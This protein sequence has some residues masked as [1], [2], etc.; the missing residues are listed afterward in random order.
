MK[1]DH[2]DPSDVIKKLG[3]IVLEKIPQ[4]HF[5]VRVT[6]SGGDGKMRMFDLLNN[7]V[8]KNRMF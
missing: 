2:Y 4:G 5:P 7:F 8:F 6:A 3:G 1:R